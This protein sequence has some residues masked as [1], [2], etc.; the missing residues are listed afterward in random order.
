MSCFFLG[1]GVI[2][3]GVL[4]LHSGRVGWHGLDVPALP[5]AGW[6]VIFGGIIMC[7]VAIRAMLRGEH[8]PKRYTDEE[9]AKV[10]E[11][12]DRM[13]FREHGYWPEEPKSDKDR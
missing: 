8:K 5:W 1:I 4:T 13:F 10:I 3:L 9:L 2:I 11:E 12:L 7:I 6:G